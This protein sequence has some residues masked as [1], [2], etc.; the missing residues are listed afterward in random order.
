MSSL[1]FD[2]LGELVFL[3][4]ELAALPVEDTG[5]NIKIRAEALRKI[6]HKINEMQFEVPIFDE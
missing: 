2:L 4:N 3:V 6:E 5:E 1:W